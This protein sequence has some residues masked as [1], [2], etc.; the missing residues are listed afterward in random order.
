MSQVGTVTLPAAR[1]EE[2][3]HDARLVNLIVLGRIVNALRFAHTAPL[4]VYDEGTPRA[5]RQLIVAF[6]LQVATCQEALDALKKMNQPMSDH[7]TWKQRIA[8]LFR[9]PEVQELEGALI[10]DVRRKLAFH[11]DIDAMR[12][13]LNRA[14]LGDATILAMATSQKKDVYFTFSEE[15]AASYLV[16]GHG[17]TRAEHTSLL[18]PLFRRATDL[19]IRIADEVEGMATALVGDLG[20]RGVWTDVP[21]AS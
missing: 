21:S 10:R 3:R 19:T 14:P 5:A 2:L 17:M 11:F 15:V 16:S 18:A 9:D 12:E 7:L 1:L 6:F 8:P 4:E 20:L 13:G